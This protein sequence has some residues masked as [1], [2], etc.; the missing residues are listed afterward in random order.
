[1]NKN[2]E[3]YLS[4]YIRQCKRRGLNKDTVLH[5]AVC[6][7]LGEYEYDRAINDCKMEW[8]DTFNKLWEEAN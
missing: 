2:L 1:M 3:T 6:D 5:K 8:N 4:K 7:Y